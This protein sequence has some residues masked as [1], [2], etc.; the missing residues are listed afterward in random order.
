MYCGSWH[1]LNLYIGAEGQTRTDVPFGAA[2]KAAAIAT[3]RLQQKTPTRL[4]F[5]DRRVGYVTLEYY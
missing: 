3:M 1:I 5:F 4:R 2:Y